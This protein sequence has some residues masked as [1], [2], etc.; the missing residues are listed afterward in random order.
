MQFTD[1]KSQ[2]HSPLV[3]FLATTVLVKSGCASD[4]NNYRGISVSS[5]L[6][7]L[8]CSIINERAQ[9]HLQENQPLHKSQIGFT[10]GFRTSD[11]LST[12]KSLID[13]HVTY[14]SRGKIFA[15]FVDLWKAFDSVWHNGLFKQ[16]TKSGCYWK[17][18]QFNSKYVWQYNMQ[19][20]KLMVQSLRLSNITKECVR[21]VF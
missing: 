19:C 20:K 21:V 6:G 17:D 1:S 12:L 15:C 5:F 18:I 13:P 14:S 8:F 9:N 10:P 2:Q 3:A 4:P 16:I 11:H 7:K